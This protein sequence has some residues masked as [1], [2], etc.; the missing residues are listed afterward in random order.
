M[1]ISPGETPILLVDDEEM[2]L[3]TASFICASA[4]MSDVRTCSDSR[5]VT[6]LLSESLPAAVLLDISMPH[7]NGYELL[8]EIQE[9]HPELPV[10]MLTADNDVDTAIRC[11]RQGAFD[12]LLKPVDEERLVTC[13]RHAVEM[14]AVRAENASLRDQL[15]ARALA[16]P[17]H[18][19]GIVT[20]DPVMQGIFRYIEAIAVSSWPVLVTGETGAGKELIAHA[21]HRASQ[22][23]GEFVPV[24]VAGVDDALFSD[25]LFGP[26]T[27]AFTGAEQP[28][29]GMIEQAAGGTLFLDEIGDL[30]PHSQTK[31]LRLIQENRYHQVGSDRSRP[32]EVRI[33]AATN[34]NLQKLIEQG[35]FRRDLYYR[36]QTHCIEIPSLRER[37]EDVPLLV[38]HFLH[39][40]ARALDRR[41]PSIPAELFTLLRAYHFPGNVRELE[42]LVSDAVSRHEAGVLSTRIFRDR[43]G[44]GLGARPSAGSTGDNRE[45]EPER[46]TF[47]GA[48]PTLREAEEILIRKALEI[49]RGNQTIA[50]QML[51]LS[52]R[53]LNN[54]LHRAGM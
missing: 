21:I 13:I 54:R 49:A 18:F 2:F 27:G 44:N 8:V 41:P 23:H 20:R 12:Y 35:Q 1:S 33:V 50:A 24:N 37:T 28:R 14:S 53:A 4:G 6:A 7:K 3:Q 32:C 34:C 16:H 45:E 38:E 22:R 9:S 31:L 25:M 29:A 5:K 15:L 46:L 30:S 52:R 11:I 17:E 48:F 26:V 36:L 51:G 39:K 43:I 40:A 42:A 47:H 10:V 19:S